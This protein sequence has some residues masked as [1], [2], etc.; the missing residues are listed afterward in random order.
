MEELRGKNS[1]SLKSP[2]TTKVS[3][4]FKGGRKRNIIRIGSL[5]SKP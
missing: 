2:K 1:P 4:Y 3:A 5:N